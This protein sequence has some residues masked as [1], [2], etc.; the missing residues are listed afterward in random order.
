MKKLVFIFAAFVAVSFSACGNKAAKSDN[1]AKADSTV[2]TEGKTCKS[3]CDSSA[4]KSACDS[5][6]CKTKCDSTA[7]KAKCDSTAQKEHA[8]K[9]NCKSNCK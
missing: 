7:C 9:S 2:V 6:A 8:C 5:A 3:A 4:C 1:A